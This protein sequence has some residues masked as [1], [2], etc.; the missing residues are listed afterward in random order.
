VV[1]VICQKGRIA[2]AHGLSNRIR[3]VAP[4]WSPSNACCLGSTRVQVKTASRLEHPFWQGLRSCQTDRQTDRR[5]YHATPS[6]TI[7][8]IYTYVVLRCGL[9][10]MN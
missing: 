8:R 3:K 1:K 6:V 2:A 5:T 7:G 9:I 4:I 10:I